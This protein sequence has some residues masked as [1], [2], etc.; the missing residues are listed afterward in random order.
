MPLL[1]KPRDPNYGVKKVRKRN[2]ISRKPIHASVLP[3]TKTY[4]E[5]KH[6]TMSPGQVVDAAI[7][8]YAERR[9]LSEVSIK[10]RESVKLE[11]LNTTVSQETIAYF[12]FMSGAMTP[13]ELIDAAIML[14]KKLAKDIQ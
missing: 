5:S 9:E 4:I 11:K 12:S 8:L 2:V 10:E 1:Q 7:K 3:E 13:G 6:E 14:Y